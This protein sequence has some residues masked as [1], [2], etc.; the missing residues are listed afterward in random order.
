MN[1]LQDFPY[2]VLIVDDEIRDWAEPMKDR[3][4]SLARHLGYNKIE[5]QLAYD[6]DE[7]YRK[8]ARQHFHVV[9]LYI[10]LPE[11][12][13]EIISVE[14]GLTL[15]R[16]FPYVGFP[17]RL[18]YSITLAVEVIQKSPSEAVQVMEIPADHY[19]K[20]TGSELYEKQEG[21]IILKVTEWAKRVM[22]SLALD[23][24][25][26]HK[27]EGEQRDPPLT[28][29]GA[30]L[31]FGPDLLPPLLARHLQDL[32]NYWETKDS[33]RTDAAIKF[34]E[35]TALLALAQTAVLLKADCKPT[36]LTTDDRISTCL[37]TLSAWRAH[38]D[39][40]NWGN[41]LTPQAIASFRDA[42]AARNE[43][44]HTRKPNDALQAWAALR[45]P[46]QYAM[47]LAAYWVRHPLCINLRYNRDGWNAELLA[48]TAY[49]RKRRRL[50]QR[51]DF[52]GEAVQ[53]GVWQNVWRIDGDTP[54]PKPLCW[55]GWL[56]A[57]SKSERPW[58]LPIH[59]DAK[60]RTVWLDLDSGQT[61]SR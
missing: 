44:R 32:A 54:R 49:P 47:D 33:R 34:I 30:Y 37:A 10:R 35:S 31:H 21:A 38:L 17:K 28:M 59:L 43:E 39:G 23:T 42:L 14:T 4:L 3:L 36:L 41:Y 16:S 19:A 60:N 5:V 45:V 51:L 2:Q 11:R 18:I 61:L 25:S 8:L 53:S 24:L 55:D 13:G 12:K 15:A 9:S 20:A 7:A 56:E 50:P 29:I 46:L 52:P 40:W 6:A 57:D 22:D 48:G 26:L 1:T 58:W 27:A